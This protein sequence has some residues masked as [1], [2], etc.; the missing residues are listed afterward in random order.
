MIINLHKKTSLFFD[1]IYLFGIFVGLVSLLKGHVRIGLKRMIHPVGY[2]RYPVFNLIIKSLKGKTNLDV[3]DIGS[4]KLLALFLALRKGFKAHATDIQDHEIFTVWQTYYNNCKSNRLIE[5]D[6]FK[7]AYLF[8][9]EIQDGRAL[10]YADNSFDLVYSISVL[11]HIPGDGD[12]IAMKEM[13]RVLK[14]GGIAI[15]EVP[16]SDKE[17]E[18]YVNKDVYERECLNEAIFYQRHYDRETIYSRIINQAKLLIDSIHIINERYPFELIMGKLN[19][20]LQLPLLFISPII[21]M[22]NHTRI[23]IKNFNCFTDARGGGAKNIT[24]FLRKQ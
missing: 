8:D 12:S 5:I 17:S 4:P 10:S 24:L 7:N 19:T 13:V 11:E 16:F 18:T 9:P 20:I 15:I 21:S 14:P 2:W 22:L 6:K 3:L 23:E 1:H